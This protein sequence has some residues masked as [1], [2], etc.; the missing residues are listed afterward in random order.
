MRIDNKN[1]NQNRNNNKNNKHETQPSHVLI[2]LSPNEDAR[3][4]ATVPHHLTSESE[5]R[6]ETPKGLG[7]C[8]V[9]R[10]KMVLTIPLSTTTHLTD[11]FCF[12]LCQ[13]GIPKMFSAD[14]NTSAHIYSRKSLRNK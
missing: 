1:N 10:K 4:L 5:A 6:S 8:A 13:P 12:L 7:P 2:H 11:V 9:N 14:N 3:L